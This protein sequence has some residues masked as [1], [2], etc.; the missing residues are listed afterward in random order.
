MITN[1]GFL[2]CITFVQ[3]TVYNAPW[4]NN[5]LQAMLQIYLTRE[6]LAKIIRFSRREKV[7]KK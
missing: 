3:C 6:Y 1:D 5:A 4:R 7:N 2:E